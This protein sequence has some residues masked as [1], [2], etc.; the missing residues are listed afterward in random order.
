MPRAEELG[1][2]FEPSAQAIRNWVRQADRDAGRRQD[3]LTTVE[4]EEVRRL[5]R[6]NRALREE[7]EILRKAAAWFERETWS[8]GGASVDQSRCGLEGQERPRRGL[9]VPY[10]QITRDQVTSVRTSLKT[11]GKRTSLA[12]AAAKAS[13]DARALPDLYREQSEYLDVVESEWGAE[14]TERK[15][16]REAMATVQKNLERV[17]ANMAKAAKAKTEGVKPSDVLEKTARIEAA[18]TEAGERLR[19]RWQLEQAA[20]EREIKQREREAAEL[21]RGAK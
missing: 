18:V 1:R 8:G 9:Y 14:G 15:K 19:A 10:A 6:E 20:R 11:G 17:N 12:D 7:R 16:L 13:G 3:G 5:R 2:Q 21:A 4:Q